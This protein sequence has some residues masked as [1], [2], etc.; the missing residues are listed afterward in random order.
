MIK[1]HLFSYCLGKQ[2]VVSEIMVLEVP[3]RC[4]FQRHKESRTF[5]K[6]QLLDSWV[7]LWKVTREPDI[8]A[9]WP[10]HVIDYFEFQITYYKLRNN[11]V[12][13][14]VVVKK[15]PDNGVLL[16]IFLLAISITKSC[17]FFFFK[18]LS[19]FPPEYFFITSVLP[20]I[21]IL[22]C[23]LPHLFRAVAAFWMVF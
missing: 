23:P 15:K 11:I 7:A 10:G 9:V 18:D 8:L 19:I 1:F 6:E 16:I 17:Q 2:N 20:P 5:H 22:V 21:T 14:R 12:F 13:H 3:N 4:S